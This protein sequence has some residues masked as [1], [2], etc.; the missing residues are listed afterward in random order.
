MLRGE[1]E[2]HDICREEIDALKKQV[3]AMKA[4]QDGD[5]DARV[6]GACVKMQAEVDNL[7]KVNI[8]KFSIF[9]EGI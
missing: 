5:L 4:E 9:I 2:N 7:A 6:Q 3:L 1:K 8:K